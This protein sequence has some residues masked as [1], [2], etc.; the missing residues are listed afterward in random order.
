MPLRKQLRGAVVAGAAA[1]A[2]TTGMLTGLAPVPGGAS[3]H[4]EAPLIA[5]DPQVDTTDVYLFRSPDN[6]DTVTLVA[7]WLP[8]E[9]PAGGP[10]FYSFDDQAMYDLRV[11]NNGNAKPDM[12]FRFDFTDHYRNL[13]TFLYN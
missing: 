1:V 2:L 6:P 10:N 8:F 4:R 5:A 9:E 3:S 13:N 7:S 12:I 11:D